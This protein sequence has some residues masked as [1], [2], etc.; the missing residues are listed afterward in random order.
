MTANVFKFVDAISASPTTLLD[1]DDG[2]PFWVVEGTQ[3]PAPD[4][5]DSV[6][7]NNLRDGSID[8]AS[9]Y[10]DRV[11]SLV[12]SLNPASSAEAQLTAVQTLG[13]LLNSEQWLQWQG[14][15]V[16]NPVFFRTKRASAKV[17]DELLIDLPLRQVTV[18]LRAE[19]FGYGLPVTSGTVTIANDPTTGTNKMSYVFPTILGDVPAPLWMSFSN[20]NTRILGKA[21]VSVECGPS[22]PTTPLFSQAFSTIAATGWSSASATADAAAIGGTTNVLTKASGSLSYTGNSTITAPAGDY[23]VFLRLKTTS[24]GVTVTVKAGG[25]TVGTTVTPLSNAS[26]F[27]WY[28]FGVARLPQA[29]PKAII[30]VPTSPTTTGI[31]S[32]TFSMTGGS[33]AISLDAVLLVPAGLDDA[34]T[35]SLL[36]APGSTSSPLPAYLDGY[37]DVMWIG[38]GNVYETINFAG[39]LPQVTPGTVNVLTFLVGIFP[40]FTDLITD[41]T[42]VTYRYYPRYL[43]AR[44]ATT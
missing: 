18:E 3:T 26:A 22:A 12:L 44:P 4:R 6:S 11:I 36:I 9:P 33:G 28:D 38:A 15:N 17:I 16:T 13:R 37:A 20:G 25:A 1:L 30:P 23:R 41:T 27:Q 21:V 43:Y 32:A 35:S 7:Y 34:K 2:N 29:H 24:T 5:R 10:S 31:I 8:T 40:N 19:P 42:S 14:T 39:R